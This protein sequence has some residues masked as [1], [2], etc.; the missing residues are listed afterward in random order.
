MFRKCWVPGEWSAVWEE[1]QVVWSA[2]PSNAAASYRHPARPSQQGCLKPCPPA[3]GLPTVLHPGQRGCLS[4]SPAEGTREGRK[5]WPSFAG[6]EQSRGPWGHPSWGA[7]LLALP[8][9]GTE[10]T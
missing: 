3:V 9:D 8:G 5:L 10:A 2:G 1:G 6:L 4:A 7:F